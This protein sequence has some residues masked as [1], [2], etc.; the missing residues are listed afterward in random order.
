MADSNPLL[1][2]ITGDIPNPALKAALSKL[3]STPILSGVNIWPPIIPK[4]IRL[5]LFA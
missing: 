5:T 1:N 3:Y 2:P 4:F